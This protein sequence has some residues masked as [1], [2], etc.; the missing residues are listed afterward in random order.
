MRFALWLQS[1]WQ[2]RGIYAWLMFPLSLVYC[3]L[4]AL[5]REAY[6]SGLLKT[7]R[8]ARPVIV[9]GNISV[10]GTGKTPLVI[11]IAEHLA[12]NGLRPAVISRGYGGRATDF[13]MPVHAH[14]PAAL[15]GDE[16]VMIARSLGCP[17]GID[18]DR[19]SAANLR[20]TSNL[21]RSPELRA[22]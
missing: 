17:V 10:G 6:E 9:V 13:P 12:R 20:S 18:P 21:K 19:V 11:W 15:A 22:R 3:L 1:Q 8:I 14:T 7:H 5:R 4:M 16:P 2:K